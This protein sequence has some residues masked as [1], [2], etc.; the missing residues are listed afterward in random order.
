[1]P[2]SGDQDSRKQYSAAGSKGVGVAGSDAKRSVVGRRDDDTKQQQQQQQQQR[3]SERKAQM[4][5]QVAKEREQEE[6]RGKRVEGGSA[7]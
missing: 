5:D 7:R 6:Q 2:P 4:G 3:A 1:M